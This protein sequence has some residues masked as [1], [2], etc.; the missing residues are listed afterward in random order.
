MPAWSD[1]RDTARSRGALALELYR[2]ESTPIVPPE[3]LGETLPAHLEYQKQ[4]EAQGNLVLAGPLS[5]D[6][7]EQMNGAGMIIYRADSMEQARQMAENDPMH[8]QGKRGFTL[9]RWLV[10]EGSL[11][12]SVKLSGQTMMLE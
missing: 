2:I 4:M 9:R 5:D 1:Y 7:G 12:I 6:S 3:Q 8:A 10:N 11:T